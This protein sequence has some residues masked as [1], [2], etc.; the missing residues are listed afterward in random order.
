MKQSNA[1]TAPKKQHTF[2]RRLLAFALTVVLVLGALAAVVHRD[3]LNLDFLRRW[4]TYRSI[5]TSQTGLT[6][7]FTHGS[8]DRLD[9]ACLESGF[10]FSSTAG[11]TSASFVSTISDQNR[12]RTQSKLVKDRT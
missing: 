4:L 3:K 2:L 6:E 1:D 12:H 9:M 11:F 8:G 10:L 5:Q 7:P